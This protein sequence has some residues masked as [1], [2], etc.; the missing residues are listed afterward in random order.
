M[1]G[2]QYTDPMQLMLKENLQH[3]LTNTFELRIEGVLQCQNILYVPN[4][5]GRKEDYDGC[6]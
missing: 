6:I 3:G 5:Y 4:I 1:K 2:K